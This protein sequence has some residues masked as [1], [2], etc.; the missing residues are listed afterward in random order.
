[1]KGTSLFDGDTV[2]FDTGDRANGSLYIHI[3]NAS[4]ADVDEVVDSLRGVSLWSASPP[5][6]V[7]DKDRDT[8]RRE[9][10]FCEAAGYRSESGY[11]VIS[12]FDHPAFPSQPI[13]YAAWLEVLDRDE[14]FAREVG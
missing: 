3:P 10:R 6:S 11:F 4:D 14:R 13:R 12:R 2:W 7:A 5:K 1:M 9:L 8:Y